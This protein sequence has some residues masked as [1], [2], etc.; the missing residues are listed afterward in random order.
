MGIRS[1]AFLSIVAYLASHLIQNWMTQTK[2]EHQH[3]I[4]FLAFAYHIGLFHVW[5]ALCVLVLA[6]NVI[7]Q[8][9]SWVDR[10][11]S[12]LPVVSAW[13]IVLKK[14]PVLPD[15]MADRPPFLRDIRSTALKPLIW[16]KR[17]PA[18]VTIQLFGLSIRDLVVDPSACW[19][20]IR[21]GLSFSNPSTLG[22]GFAIVITLWG[23]RLSY[24]F[25]R[26]GGYWVGGEDYRWVRVRQWFGALKGQDLS[27]CLFGST[28][29][30]RLF[31]AWVAFPIFDVLFICFLQL[32]LLLVGLTGPLLR[33]LLTAPT[34]AGFDVA[35]LCVFTCL[36]LVETV[37][38]QQQYNFQS[39]KYAM[40]GKVPVAT[41]YD[42][43]VDESVG[44]IRS[45]LF[46]LSRHPNFAAEISI[47]WTIYICS[48]VP[49]FGYYNFYNFSITGVVFLTAIFLGSTPLTE[50]LSKEKYGKFYQEYQR[51]VS[52]LVPFT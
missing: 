1:Y 10:L 26:K 36:L 43:S 23:L 3:D 18:L 30:G 32:W 39:R 52:R 17:N 37:A 8:E 49:S 29:V 47:W 6:L 34:M 19:L 25:W 21:S 2:L 11:W 12:V 5:A 20:R 27:L 22:L 42:E 46:S 15:S 50:D 48:V 28:T 44:F 33:R 9:V 14:L 38:D 45:G 16:D 35:L 31:G 13:L 7:T 24:N 51:R 4:D 40:R 41:S